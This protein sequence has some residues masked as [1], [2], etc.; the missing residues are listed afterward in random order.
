MMARYHES[1]FPVLEELGIG[2]VAFSPL[3]NGL[4]SGRYNLNSTFEP[5]TDYRSSMPQFR[6]ESFDANKD[7][8]LLLRNLAEEKQA[9]PAQI[10]LAWMLCKKPWIVPIP[11]T[12]KFSRLKEN[13]EAAHVILSADEVRQIDVALSFMNMSDV[14]GGSPITEKS[15]TH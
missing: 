7:L 6:P 15:S 9:T 2:F 11:G 4:L 12:R 8:F 14:F 1:L 3:A 13:A 10:S 5:G